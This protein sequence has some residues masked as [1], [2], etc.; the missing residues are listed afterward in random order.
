M[1]NIMV[2]KDGF[3]K[4]VERIFN[5]FGEDVS[6]KKLI[7]KK[8]RYRK[9]DNDYYKCV[10]EHCFIVD[11]NS[12]IHFVSSKPISGVKTYGSYVTSSPRSFDASVLEFDEIND[13]VE[14]EN[15]NYP[16]IRK[17]PNLIITMKGFSDK[18]NDDILS[19]SDEDIE[20]YSRYYK[21]FLTDVSVKSRVRK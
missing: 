18:D 7:D 12:D 20:K 15:N 6:V 13:L 16:F 1:E 2:D 8:K 5:D 3:Y 11:N 17:I 4:L 14:R 9:V 10:I 19:I 21:E